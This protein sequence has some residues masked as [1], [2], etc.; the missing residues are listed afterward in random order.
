MIKASNLGIENFDIASKLKNALDFKNIYVKNDAKCAGLCEKE[1]GSLKEYSN[2]VF[3]C[4]GTGIGSAVFMEDKLLSAKE[5][6]GFELGHMVINE[7]GKICSCGR[8]GCFEVYASMKAF[9]ENITKRM[10]IDNC[11]G[12]NIYEIVEKNKDKVQDIIDEYI[13]YLCVGFINIIN[14][15]EPEAICIGGSFAHFKNILLEPLVERLHNNCESFDD[16]IPD[17]VIAKMGNDAGVIG[18]T[19]I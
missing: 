11:N 9:K 14:I 10:N 3:I 15:F 19:I 2:C 4:L 16:I 7:N 12:A 5:Y 13:K 18:A 8:K 6:S 17:I 1:F